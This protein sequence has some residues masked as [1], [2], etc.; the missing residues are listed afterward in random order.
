[1]KILPLLTAFFLLPLLTAHAQ[2][3]SLPY[4]V[5]LGVAQDGG[6]PHIGCQR[7]CCKLSWKNEAMR[8][9]VVSLALVDPAEKKWWLFEAT[10]DINEQL[11]LFSA[12]T[13]NTYSYLPQ[14]IFITHAHIGHYTGLMELGR[15]A[16]GAKE[17]PVYTL[18]RMAA[19][20]ENNGPWGQLVQLKN[21]ALKILNTD[22][23]LSLTPQVDIIPFTVPHRDEYSETAGFYIF[24]KNKKYVFI[25]DIDKWSK[26][27]KNILTVVK[28]VDIA[29]LDATF[30]NPGELPN[31]NMAEVPHPFVI[32]TMTLFEKEN[33]AIKKKI[34]FIHFNHT[35]PILWDEGQRAQIIQA[36]FNIAIQGDIYK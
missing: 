18:P 7:Q 5:V 28:N 29:F 8:R 17:I 19:F 22:S 25:P 2:P 14:G 24:T 4:V 1:M 35:N 6:Y 21:I 36:G 26:F 3:D 23:I 15:E 31:R 20:L 13:Q 12:L 10:P 32:E 9:H 27:E 11:H 30:C 33:I 16:L 34:H